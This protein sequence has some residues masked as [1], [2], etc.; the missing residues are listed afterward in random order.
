MMTFLMYLGGYIAIGFVVLAVVLRLRP[1]WAWEPKMEKVKIGTK[2]YSSS[3]VEAVLGQFA[4][5]FWKW[6]TTGYYN[7]A[8]GVDME[9]QAK[10]W[11]DE[12]VKAIANLASQEFD[13]ID[14][15][16]VGWESRHDTSV[17][18]VAVTALWPIALLAVMGSMVLHA[19]QRSLNNKSRLLVEMERELFEARKEVDELMRRG[20]V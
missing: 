12:V 16:Q 11:R 2:K 18:V 1:E 10:A 17:C 19:S 14:K 7:Y 4:G 5:G 13:V 8:Q 20:E 15:R 6:I 9:V 3:D